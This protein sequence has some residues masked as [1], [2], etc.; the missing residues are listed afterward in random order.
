MSICLH[1]N[2]SNEVQ[3][4]SN[5]LNVARGK[6]GSMEELADQ[7]VKRAGFAFDEALDLYAKVNGTMMPDIKPGLQQQQ[8]TELNAS[9]RY[10]NL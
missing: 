10:L 2:Y 5:E 6:L 9:V 8:I 4:L 3:I 1:A 7:A